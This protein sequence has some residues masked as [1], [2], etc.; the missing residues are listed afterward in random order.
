MKKKT[1]M[2]SALLALMTSATISVKAQTNWQYSYDN[3]GNRTQRVVTTGTPARKKNSTAKLIDD[4]KVTAIMINNRNGIKVEVLGYNSSD[5]AE[6][7]VYNLSGM[8]L[9]SKRIE[10]EIT[11]LNLGKLRRG[12]YIL[13]L[14]LNGETKNCKFNK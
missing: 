7:F 14:E 11:T 3:T 5:M 1:I 6:A 2:K 13:A 9:I 8:Q 4:E 10:S 12:T